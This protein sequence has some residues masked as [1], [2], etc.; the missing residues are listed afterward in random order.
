MTYYVVIF[1]FH[2]CELY[3]VILTFRVIIMTFYV[4]TICPSV[5]EMSFY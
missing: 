4:I 3:I 5:V 2:D 1:L